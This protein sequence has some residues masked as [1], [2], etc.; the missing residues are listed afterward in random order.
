MFIIYEPKRSRCGNHFTTFTL[1]GNW[2][3]ELLA[4]NFIIILCLSL[5]NASSM[6][7]SLSTPN[8]VSDTTEPKLNKITP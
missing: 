8:V 4:S 2:I 3:S 1:A 7:F 6:L 5:E